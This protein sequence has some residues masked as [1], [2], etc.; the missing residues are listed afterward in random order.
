MRSINNGFGRAVSLV[1]AIAMAVALI[2]GQLSG[3]ELSAYAAGGNIASWNY[4]STAGIMQKTPANGGE[5]L[6]G[7][8]LQF[9]NGT[10]TP[11]YSSGGFSITDWTGADASWLVEL[12]TLGFT[13]PHITFDTRSSGTGP[14][15][16]KV[17][18]SNDGLDFADV[19]DGIFSV[20]T[21]TLSSRSF[22]NGATTLPLATGGKSVD[23][24]STLYI[25]IIRASNISSRA[26][27]GSYSDTEPTAV[28]GT[29]QINNIVISSPSDAGP[30]ILNLPTASP[31]SGEY[32]PL[33]LV[34]LSADPGATIY[35]TTDDSTP[36][37][38]ST[39][40]SEPI[41]T[42]AFPDP[43][44][45]KAFAVKAEAI[46]SSI[47]T[48]VYTLEPDQGD[49][50]LDGT[51]G[52]LAEWDY[53]AKPMV[54]FLPATGGD[55]MESSTF[56]AFTNTSAKTLDYTTGGIAATDFSVPF[57]YWLIETSAKGFMNINLSF[58]MRA[59][60]TG[61]KDFTLQY[62]LDNNTWTDAGSFNM[63]GGGLG[64][65]DIRSQFAVDLSTYN[66]IIADIDNLYLRLLVSSAVS[67]NG[68]ILGS[69]TNTINNI[70]LTG[71]YILY[72]NQVMPPFAD[73][74]EI[75]KLGETV[76]FTSDT[77]GASTMVS[78]DSLSFSPAS[79][80]L[81][82]ELPKTIYV[83]AVKNNMIDSRVVRLDFTQRK[84]SEV[85]S[86]AVSGQVLPDTVIFLTAESDVAIHYAM[87][88][89]VGK[90]GSETVHDEAVYSGSIL[91]SADILPVEIVA[92]AELV[93]YIPSDDTTFQYTPIP[94]VDP[95]PDPDPGPDPDP[96]TDHD[97]DP[98]IDPAPDSDPDTDTDPDT[99]PDPAPIAD[100]S[101]L[102]SYLAAY[103]SLI[104]TN[105]TV[106]SW[107]VY[108]NASAAGLTVD[109]DEH[110][111]QQ[112]VDAV[113]AAIAD[114]FA[115]LITT[116]SAYFNLQEKLDALK[117]L[118]AELNTLDNTGYTAETW[119]VFRAVLTEANEFLKRDTSVT[120]AEEVQVIIDNLNKAVAQLATK[121][122]NDPGKNSN[123][124]SNDPP[125]QTSVNPPSLVP[126]TPDPVATPPDI[127]SDD[128]GI[129]TIFPEETVTGS[130]AFFELTQLTLDSAQETAGINNSTVI[131]IKLDH[132]E[133]ASTVELTLPENLGKTLS[134]A[135]L[136][137]KLS[138]SIL[139]LAFP[140]ETLENLAENKKLTIS[141]AKNQDDSFSVQL[142]L[143]GTAMTEIDGG[144]IVSLP[145]D[146]LAA[147][148][149]TPSGYVPAI[150][151]QFSEDI[152]AMSAI[153]GGSLL[154]KTD[155]PVTVRIIDKKTQYI[156]VSDLHWAADCIAF[157]SSR[158][159]LIGTSATEFSPDNNMSRAMVAAVLFRLSGSHTVDDSLIFS[160][161]EP[162]QWYTDAI[163][164]ASANAIINGINNGEFGTNHDVSR[165]EIAVV[166]QRFAEMIKFNITSDIS[167]DGFPD[168]S[169]VNS[170]ATSALQWVFG[171]GIMH[172]DDSGNLN[173]AGTITRAE[174]A[175]LIQRFV[176]FLLQ[177]KVG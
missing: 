137:L 84:L 141:I 48:F 43:V 5:N 20:T 36:T 125:P 129:V 93:G 163:I 172:T 128:S 58:S 118:T 59:S 51:N 1:I 98:D 166:L 96:D 150:I 90:V 55:Y 2:I 74:P 79:S 144:I 18:I 143:S 103:N 154:F 63:A 101:I 92:W 105:Y 24:Q 67:A 66:D 122:N 108:S 89:K 149:N 12:S 104:P 173:P 26:G 52:N 14:R 176:T 116:D 100:K 33:P 54:K 80:I 126:V 57:S 19:P 142:S 95:D 159:L 145:V 68:G 73:K 4:T 175:A 21:T 162:G 161:V 85:E 127:I 147:I 81:L 112:Q 123:L 7:A 153:A 106:A 30:V 135:G 138:S 110:A 99:D 177:S 39:V 91:L 72:E 65:A 119:I 8:T 77:P 164:W 156:D 170:W 158:G 132:S 71:D 17:Q 117:A 107:A 130:T 136:S 16:F 78:D 155:A 45:L 113:V 139:S 160:D 40:Y 53:Y 111:T 50:D 168:A 35:F 171:T 76:S 23:N 9:G 131:E 151:S 167:I 157:V 69:G 109:H 62:S 64:L 13:S 11:G 3:F 47:A 87:T 133:N 94:D 44:T 31:E 56:S 29:S 34:T 25:R 148:E 169:A 146:T 6:T 49:L 70:K 174:F 15:D 38:G 115:E 82:S 165:E 120:V 61:P 60:N 41:D 102:K 28:S 42:S 97:L 121:K 134:D 114:A 124:P 75:T 46:D 83:K 37:T 10:V 152:I 88:T 86:S 22:G 32:A 140:K 27:T